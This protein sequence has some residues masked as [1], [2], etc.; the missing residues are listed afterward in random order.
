MNLTPPKLA[1]HC[2]SLLKSKYNE[3]KKNENQSRVVY[4]SAKHLNNCVDCANWKRNAIFI[5]TCCA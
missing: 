2:L 1:P 3:N 5:D 4:E